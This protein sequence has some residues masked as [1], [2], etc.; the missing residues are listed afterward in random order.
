M[1]AFNGTKMKRVG[2]VLAFVAFF[3]LLNYKLFIEPARSGAAAARKNPAPMAGAGRA[4]GRLVKDEDPNH[5]DL[6]GFQFDPRAAL[7]EKLLL[8]EIF[9][10]G[11][12]L[13]K[14]V[15]KSIIVVGDPV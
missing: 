7:S 10:P 11:Y 12:N 9:V 4:T 1:T 2:L 6:P 13:T 15:F 14:Q 8:E 5:G 3:T